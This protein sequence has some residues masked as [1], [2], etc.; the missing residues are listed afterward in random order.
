MENELRDIKPLLEIPDS[1]YYI[2]L[3]LV[4]LG[5]MLLVAL[6]WFLV[7]KFWKKRKIN[8][9]KVYFEQF[10]NLDWNNVK[11]SAYEAT[12]LGRKLTLENERAK[13]IYSQLVPMLVAYKYRKKVPALDEE[14]LKQYNLLVHIIDESI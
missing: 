8:M 6:L 2:F 13:E 14:T 10:K 9:Q 3:G 11:A 1:S 12:E 7:K 5:I 4:A